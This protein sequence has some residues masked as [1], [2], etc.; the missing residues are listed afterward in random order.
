MADKKISQLSNASTP[1]TGSE[2]LAIVQGGATVKATA[3]N[4]AALGLPSQSGNDGKYLLTNGS[5]AVWVPLL[6]IPKIATCRYQYTGGTPVVTYQTINIQDAYFTSSISGTSN[7]YLVLTLVDGGIMNGPSVSASPIY[8]S[9]T[10][11]N[12][13]ADYGSSDVYNLYLYWKDGSGNL[14]NMGTGYFTID[15]VNIVLIWM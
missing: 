13:Y 11:Y 8:Q 6:Q 7:E 1:L 5:N 4:V 9:G 2:E 15:Y 10:V 3:N 12:C 14:L